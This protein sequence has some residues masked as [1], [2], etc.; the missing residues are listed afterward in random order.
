[1]LSIQKPSLDRERLHFGKG[2]VTLSPGDWRRWI[3][4]AFDR[5]P[6]GPKFDRWQRE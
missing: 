6:E 5:R 3:L 2:L 4:I 1:M